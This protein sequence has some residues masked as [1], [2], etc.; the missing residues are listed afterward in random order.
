MPNNI[1][2]PKNVYSGWYQPVPTTFASPPINF[3]EKLKLQLAEDFDIT[4]HK[5]SILLWKTSYLRDC[6]T[7]KA[8]WK[9]NYIYNYSQY[10]P[11]SAR[12]QIL[13]NCSDV[14]WHLIKKLMRQLEQILFTFL[15]QLNILHRWLR[16]TCTYASIFCLL[17]AHVEILTP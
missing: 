15:E 2:L 9:S 10:F 7:R 1:Y 4:G 12:F 3:W 16:F 11:N 17:F 13:T 8:I 6:T 14:R 5:L